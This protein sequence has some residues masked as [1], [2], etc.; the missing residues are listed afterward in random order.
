MFVVWCV[1]PVCFRVQIGLLAAC[2]PRRTSW[3][4][5][6]GVAR[7]KQGANLHPAQPAGFLQQ[8]ARVFRGSAQAAIACGTSW[9]HVP[10]WKWKLKPEL[11][12]ISLP[13]VFINAPAVSQDS[14]HKVTADMLVSALRPPLSFHLA[15]CNMYQPLFCSC[16]RHSSHDGGHRV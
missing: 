3:Q 14:P 6:G 12:C 2:I 13:D 7:G 9:M 4:H 1:S 8:A 5:P 11:C 15:T 10:A 16:L